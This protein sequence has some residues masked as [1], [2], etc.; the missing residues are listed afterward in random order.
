[1]NTS[2]I[3]LFSIGAIVLWG[4]LLVTLGITLY[5]EKKDAKAKEV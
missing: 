5:N 3:I 2:A 1:M 4:G